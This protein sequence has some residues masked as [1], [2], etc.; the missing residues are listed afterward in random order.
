MKISK[1]EKEYIEELIEDAAT[2]SFKGWDFNYTR[3]LGGNPHFPLSW[4]YRRIINNYLPE[5][6]SLLDMGTGG[7][8]FL[9]ALK[10]L[11]KKVVATEGYNPNIKV[12]EKKLKPLN[13]D[14]VEIKKGIQENSKLPFARD[15]FDLI[16]NRHECYDSKEIHR[17]LKKKG[18]FI[19]QQVGYRDLEKLRTIFGTLT[20]EVKFNW[21]LQTAMNFLKKNDMKIIKQKEIV[22]QSRFYDIRVIVYYLKIFDWLFPGFEWKKYYR[23]LENLYILINRNGFFQDLHHRFLIVATK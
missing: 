22:A 5:S 18:V 12:A 15:S 8:E 23:Q 4:N 14:V 21:D 13:V 11:T 19:T 6:N 20:D 7:G 9:S 16:I 1:K 17:M 10:P 3:K 2:Q